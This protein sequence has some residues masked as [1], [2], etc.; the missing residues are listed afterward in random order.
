MYETSPLDDGAIVAISILSLVG[1]ISLFGT[2]IQLTSIGNKPGTQLMQEDVD[3][4]LHKMKQKWA[5]SFLA[6]SFPYNMKK[7]C[8]QAEAEENLRVLNGVRVL[9]MA[10]VVIGHS[11]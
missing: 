7:L 1:G 11:Y 4:P 10:Y 5:L 8:T 2:I 6:F 9:S 3:A